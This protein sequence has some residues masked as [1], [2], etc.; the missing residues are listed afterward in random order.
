M[1]LSDEMRRLLTDT[2]LKVHPKDFFIVSIDPSEFRLRD[3]MDDP[4]SFYSVT[5]TSDEISLVMNRD[6]WQR[7]KDQFKDPQWEGPYKI[8]TFD[9]ILDL[10]IVGYLAVISKLLAEEGIS[11]YALST[12]LRDHI[13]VKKEDAEK[14]VATLERLKKS[15]NSHK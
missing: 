6:E 4:K 2:K 7:N 14:A 11:I 3:L 9:I 1:K 8:I 12:Y 13:L 15:V 10:S 5:F